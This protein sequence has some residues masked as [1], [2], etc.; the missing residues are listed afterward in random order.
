[1]VGKHKGVVSLL[2]KEM[3]ERE[4]RHDRLVSFHCI[5]HQQTLCAKS[6]KFDHVVSVVTNCIDFIKKKRDL[7][8]RIFKQVLKDFDADYDDFLYFCAVRWTSCG[9]MLGR[10]HSL[11]PEIIQF[12]NL[13]KCPLT[14]LEDENWL[15][16]LG[17]MV[18]ITKHLNDLN[19]QLQGPDQLLHS[20]FSK[21]KSF[22]SMLNLWENQ[23]KE[24]DCT[25]SP[26]LKKYHPTSCAQYA[27]ECSSLLK[28]FNAGFQDIKS[29][30]VELD[31]FSISFNV[32]PASTPSEL[33]L[34]LM[35]L[36]SDD[37]L[38]AMYLNKPLLEFYRVHVS[39][40]QFPNL[41]ASALKWS[42]VFGSTFRNLC[43]QFFSK[44]NI[45]KSR[46]RSRL[47]DENLSMRLRVATSSVR[48]DITRL[49]KQKSF[50]SSH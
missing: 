27:L 6:V 7:N 26:T 2:K 43:E 19:V 13:K 39:K 47:T 37:T 20:M 15:C 30:Q 32:T 29:K 18:D 16:D 45:T 48:P 1:M 5:V 11:L 12:K 24:N 35:K 33:Q 44:M 28:R 17:Y 21:I 3:D 34:E 9:N 49:V 14:E 50:Q 10:F 31:I 41:R 8:N 23:L 25:H 22:T 46:Y 36:Q 42:S 4:I 40:E 38:K